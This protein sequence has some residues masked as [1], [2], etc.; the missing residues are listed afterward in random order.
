MRFV[1]PLDTEKLDE[2]ADRFTNVVTLEE[3]STVGG[4]GSGVLE[5]FADK[6]YGSK[7]LRIGLPDEF[8]DHGTQKE[9]H[10]ILEID[11]EGIT[12]KVKVFLKGE[13]RVREAIV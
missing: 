6:G 12:D 3:S 11:P 7:V 9:L 10:R 1:K 2:V 8:V 13:N 4:F 5:Y